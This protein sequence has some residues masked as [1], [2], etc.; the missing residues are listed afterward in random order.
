MRENHLVE[1]MSAERVLRKEGGGG[2][3]V[4]EW[5]SEEGRM[6]GMPCF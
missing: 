1:D 3:S 5:G 4:G 2:G 6:V